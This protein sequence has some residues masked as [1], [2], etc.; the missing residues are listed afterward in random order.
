MAGLPRTS[1]ALETVDV[2]IASYILDVNEREVL[3]HEIM[4]CFTVPMSLNIKESSYSSV[5]LL[6][7]QGLH[8][9]IVFDEL[10]GTRTGLIHNH[11]F[12]C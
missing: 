8:I 4:G 10:E 5:V 2:R 1:P 7:K 9:R 3:V 11:A 12:V 6:F